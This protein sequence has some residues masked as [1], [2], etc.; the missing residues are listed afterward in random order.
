MTNKKSVTKN[1]TP[2]A[3]K[4]PGFIE[5]VKNSSTFILHHK[6]KLGGI[7]LVYAVMYFIFIMGFSMTSSIGN[8]VD[9]S[10]SKIS[11]TGTMLSYA[12]SNM[13]NG[14]SQSD[15]I[16]LTQLLLF[17]IASMAAI[18]AIGRLKEGKEIKVLDSFYQGTARLVPTLVVC[19]VLVLAMIP[20][21]LA[22]AFLSVSLRSSGSSMESVIIFTVSAIILYFAL[23]LLSM[24]WPAFYISA[25][26]QTR[27]IKSLKE[28]I[29]LT[30][31]RRTKILGRI[32]LLFVF[33]LVIFFAALYLFAM[34]STAF[35]PYIL[36][37]TTFKIF[38][39]SQVYLY[40]LYRS[41]E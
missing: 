26:S 30:K 34:I 40:E 11:Q 12:I 3:N 18:W 27:P 25:E 22:S 23:L 21:L 36:F 1:S 7:T 10:A 38:I 5:L 39:F 15:A 41:L 33:L 24:L 4:I 32:S 8:T 31:N 19:T 13:Y 29:A 28:A 17:L 9:P 2:I 37:I 35:I 14:N 20:A 6:K 16:V